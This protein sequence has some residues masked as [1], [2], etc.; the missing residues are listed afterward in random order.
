MVIERYHLSTGN[1][2]EYRRRVSKILLEDLFLYSVVLGTG[3]P[4]KAWFV[5][6][7]L[8]KPLRFY[9]FNG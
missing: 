7:E 4:R 6:D 5:R 3:V 1:V 8:T 2:K 9:L